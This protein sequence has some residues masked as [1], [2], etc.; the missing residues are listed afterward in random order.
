[1]AAVRR[2]RSTMHVSPDPVRVYQEIVD[3]LRRERSGE[4]KGPKFQS[5]ARSMARMQ[6]RR[7][8][9]DTQ[10]ERYALA[11]LTTPG[12]MRRD[13]QTLTLHDYFTINDVLKSI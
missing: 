4:W 2:T 5:L 6:A 12:A 7:R 10:A 1:M 3:R 11:Q 8:H 13:Q 9:P